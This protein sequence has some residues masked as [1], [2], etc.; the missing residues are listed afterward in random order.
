MQSFIKPQGIPFPLC[1]LADTVYFV[2]RLTGPPLADNERG[3][4][5]GDGVLHATGTDSARLYTAAYPRS[6][7]PPYAWAVTGVGS[8]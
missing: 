7:H 2:K 5:L 4:Q 3:L 6:E 8:S 1:V